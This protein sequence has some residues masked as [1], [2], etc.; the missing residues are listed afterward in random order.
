MDV[1]GK[2]LRRPGRV[3]KAGTRKN[4]ESRGL[5]KRGLEGSEGRGD[6]G[7]SSGEGA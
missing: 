4:K 3:R 5:F 6:L 2:R 7:R 1:G